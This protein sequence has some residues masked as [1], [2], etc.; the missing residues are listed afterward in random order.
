M[1]V[2]TGRAIAYDVAVVLVFLMFGNAAHDSAADGAGHLVA[3]GACFLAALAA[4]WGVARA[5]RT[6][7]RIWPTGVVVWLVTAAVGVTLR[8]LLV[9]DAGFA[10][11]FIAITFGFL[12]VTQLGWRALAAVPPRRR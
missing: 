11:A 12:A 1:E 2:S 8:G 4:G 10:P 7:T 9:P 6:P 3:L 5:W